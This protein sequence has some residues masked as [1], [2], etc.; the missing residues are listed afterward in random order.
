MAV[1]DYPRSLDDLP[2]GGLG[3]GT[4]GRPGGGAGAGRKRPRHESMST[5]RWGDRIAYVLCWAA[6]LTLCAIA[7]AIVG[8]MAYRGVQYLRP[9]LLWSHPSGEVDQ[10]KSGGF[11]DP[12]LGTI[13]LTLIGIVIATP[14]AVAAAIWVVEYG[15]PAPL[16]RAVESGI[17]VVAGTP[18]IVLAIFGLALFQHGLFGWMSFTAEGGAVF[19]RSFLTAGAMMSLIAL[20]MV[21]GATREG[22]QS[23]PRHVREA[24]YGLGKTKIAT[25]RRVLLPAVRPNIST[26]AALGMGRIAGDT[27]IVVI[28]LGA[29]LRLESEG[30]IPG[31]DV[32]KGTGSTLTS[33][34][35]NNSPAGEGA[36]PEKAYAAAFVLLL[37]VVALNFAVDLIARR[38]AKTG[39]EGTRLGAGR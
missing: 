9:E 6:G 37:L 18:D 39:L 20:P 8:Y 25:I 24:S 28:L 32:L 38:G 21:F 31:L 29:T 30:S 14:L 33:Y 23:I 13:L 1:S 27:A 3:V 22:L 12:I 10:S 26:G 15:K 35:Y 4:G 17:E 16:A 5:W 19:G 7:F 36:A 11:L 2:H 34:V